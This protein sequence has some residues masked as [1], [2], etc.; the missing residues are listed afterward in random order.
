MNDDLPEATDVVVIGGGVIGIFTALELRRR[1]LQVLVCEKGRIAGE[2]SS[3]NWG[4]IRQ[5]G[6]DPAELPIMM[7]AIQLWER[8]SNEL[9][10]DIGFIRCGTTSLAISETQLSKMAEWVKLAHEH[11]L[12]TSL[13][14]QAQIPGLLFGGKNA[15]QHHA[16]IGGMHTSNDGRAEPWQAVPAVTKLVQHKGALVRENCAVRTMEISAG[17]ITGVVTE[18]GTVKTNQ[19]VVAAGAWSSLFMYRHGILIPQLAVAATVCRTAQLPEFFS[20]NASDGT[21][22]FRRR[23]DGGFTLAAAGR[24]TFYLGPSGCRHTLKYLPLMRQSVWST[25][26]RFGA[27]KNFPDGWATARRWSADEES[28]FER[29]RVLEPEPD[30]KLVKKAQGLFSARFPGIGTPTILNAWAGMIDT[31]PDVVP[32]IDRVPDM[33]ELIVAT[34]LSGHGF[35][36]GPGVGRIV[37]QMVAGEQLE[38]DMHRF[39]FTRFTD[40]SSLDV[41]PF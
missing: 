30:I 22:A 35:G 26:Y 12:N 28:P 25:R 3:R 8:V 29:Q 18:H 15:P 41:G 23:Q 4:W 32:I 27:P 39:R 33:P 2:Q 16:W 20:G 9:K 1:G 24:Q 21:L 31:T 10:D 14:S 40:G 6:R 5:Q 37:A 19:V 36:I 38:Y 11:G 13:I 34:G 7:D 17:E